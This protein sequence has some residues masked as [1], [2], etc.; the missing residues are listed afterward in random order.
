MSRRITRLVALLTVVGLTATGC[1]ALSGGLKGVQLPGGANLGDDPYP[2]QI[3]FGDVVD[4]VPQS[5]VRVGD[6]PVG[7]VETIA[8]EP[9]SWNAVVTVLVNRGVTLPAN[10]DAKVRTTSLLGEKF[11]ELSSP[12]QPA[13]GTLAES[14]RIGLQNAGRAAEVEEVLGAL[15]MLLNGGGVAQIK[16]ISTELNKAL[17]GREPQVRELLDNVNRL[18]GALDSRKEDINRALDGLNQLSATLVERRPSIENALQNLS[19]GLREL[20]SQRA[21][22]VNMLRALDRLSGVATDVI[23]RSREDVLADLE[24]LRP[25]L[26]NLAD[27]G[28]DLPDSLQLLLT[29]PFTDNATDAVAGDYTNL[30]VTADLDLGVILNNIL[31][32]NQT[33]LANNP[34]TAQL[35][36]NARLLAPL[37]GAD[38]QPAPVP[39]VPDTVA[40]PA[41]GAPAPPAPAAPGATATPAPAPTPSPTTTPAPTRDSGGGGLFGGLLGGGS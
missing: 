41:A 21:Q 6:V 23:N 2:V 39:G 25:I 40:P 11:V 33:P 34:L 22:L 13:P 1:G 12:A 20:E 17:S 28:Q 10:A 35:P 37:L 4:L 32:S 18:V 24:N 19:P 27:S 5:L 38:G 7:S 31:A 8:V 29:I 9:N 36:P 14:G 15:S 3:E 30:Y 26:R 16:T